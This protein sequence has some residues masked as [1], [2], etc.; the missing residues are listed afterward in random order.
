MQECLQISRA[1]LIDRCDSEEWYEEGKCDNEE[2]HERV[3]KHVYV[4]VLSTY[5]VHLMDKGDSV[6]VL[7]LR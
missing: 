1:L 5:S 3:E 6:I 4:Q 2:D 7:Y